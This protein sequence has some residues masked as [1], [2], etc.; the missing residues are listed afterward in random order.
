MRSEYQENGPPAGMEGLVAC[1]WESE[2]HDDRVQRVVPDG[3]VDLIWHPDEGLVIHGADTGPRMVELPR[4]VRLAAV[5]LRVGAAGERVGCTRL[6]GT[7]S[8]GR[9]RTH[10][11]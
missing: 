6:G 1:L 11:G 4:A 10:L 7:R 5:R 2:S 9:A 8:P 3:C